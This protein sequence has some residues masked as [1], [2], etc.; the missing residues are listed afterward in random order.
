MSLPAAPKADVLKFRILL[1]INALLALLTTLFVV[2]FYTSGTD[3]KLAAVADGRQLSIAA[4]GTVSGNMRKT[5]PDKA[6]QATDTAANPSEPAAAFD[7][8]DA[9]EASAAATQSS[10]G[11]AESEQ[12]AS[13]VAT[14]EEAVQTIRINPRTPASLPAAPVDSLQE[15]S[16]FGAI[17]KQSLTDSP[18]KAYARPFTA[19]EGK[20]LVAIVI[21]DLGQQNAITDQVISL[22]AD[23][24]LAL[25]PYSK[26]ATLWAESARNMGHETWLMLPVQ[27]IGFP[28]SDPGPLAVLAALPDS[29]NEARVKH[30]LASSVG[31][32]GVILPPNEAISEF[33]DKLA[34]PLKQIGG[35]GLAMLTTNLTEKTHARSILSN[36]KQNRMIADLVLDDSPTAQD[37]EKKLAELQTIASN[38]GMAVGVIR[39]LPVSIK[40]LEGWLGTLA[41]SPVQL[42]PL[43][44][45]IAKGNP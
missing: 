36:A 26:Q 9:S 31:Y 25:S 24:T 20:K 44:A 43:S 39:P 38:R 17:P 8:G 7:V 45:L 13:L 5:T 1:G 21:T 27:P 23:V 29:E 3:E 18:L 41:A 6:E 16:E 15:A 32:P 19:M 12:V 40:A 30:T 10:G 34:A 14:E 2:L 22:P 4:D 42:A 28:A 11:E 33:S 35:R 37:I